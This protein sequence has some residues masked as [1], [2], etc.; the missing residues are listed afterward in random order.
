M[1]EGLH[2]VWVIRKLTCIGALH[3]VCTKMFNAYTNMYIVQ[4]MI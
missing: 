4:Y 2:N 3:Y 1:E